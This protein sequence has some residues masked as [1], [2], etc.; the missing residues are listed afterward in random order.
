MN[1]NFCCEEMEMF[2]ASVKGVLEVTEEDKIIGFVFEN[3]EPVEL[4][5][6]SDQVFIPNIIFRFCPYCG[7]MLDLER[8]LTTKNDFLG[9]VVKALRGVNFQESSLTRRM[10]NFEEAMDS[11]KESAERAI[12]DEV[13]AKGVEK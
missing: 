1:D 7:K 10:A 3:D 5:I 11:I 12:S 13:A 4:I 8:K 6:K 2:F 9:C